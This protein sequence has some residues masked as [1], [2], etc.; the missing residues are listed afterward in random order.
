MSATSVGAPRVKRVLAATD[1]SRTADQVAQY[2]A[3]LAAS[4][5]AE[6]L[7]IQVLPPTDVRGGHVT[8]GAL[9]EAS[10]ELRRFA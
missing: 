5:R 8:D 3:N 7:L 4:Y 1:R 9:A 6:L 10:Q 2:A